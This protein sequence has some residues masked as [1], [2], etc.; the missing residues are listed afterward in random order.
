MRSVDGNRQKWYYDDRGSAIRVHR[1][2]NSA[3]AA[4]VRARGVEAL[5]SVA[6]F[7]GRRFDEGNQYSNAWIRRIDSRAIN[8][9][10][11]HSAM[12]P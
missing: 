6:I 4:E 3:A 2:V 10:G 11:R 8:T 7:R 12:P 9:S 1:R 5:A